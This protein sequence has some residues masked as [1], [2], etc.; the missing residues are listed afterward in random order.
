M[1]LTSMKCK[2]K[3]GF[4]SNAAGDCL[5]IDECSLFSYAC[6]NRST[7]VNKEGTFECRGTTTVMSSTTTTTALVATT[8]TTTS[9]TTTLTTTAEHRNNTVL[10][11]R[12]WVS[13]EH[14]GKD[15]T[16]SSLVRLET[17]GPWQVHS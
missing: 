7:C 4:L 9:S 17:K 13:R 15:K 11:L 6:S 16:K 12:K 5:D 3:N 8:S 14:K 2:C 1:A 10:V